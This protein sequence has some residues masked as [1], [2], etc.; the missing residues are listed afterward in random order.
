MFY[1]SR[2]RVS[3]SMPRSAPLMSKVCIRLRV[4]SPHHPCGNTSC[5]LSYYLQE[6]CKCRPSGNPQSCWRRSSS[7]V[8][9]PMVK[10]GQSKPAGLVTLIQPTA[11]SCIINTVSLFFSEIQDRPAGTP[12]TLLRRPVGR[13]HAVVL[14]EASDHVP[15]ISDQFIACTGNRDLAILLNKDTFEPDLVVLAFRENS[16]SKGT[17]GMV[18]L[19]VRSLLRRSSLS[20]TLTHCY[21]LL[22]PHPQCCGQ[23][24]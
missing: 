7:P 4:T 10:F 14:Q 23:D 13:F 9:L 20:G 18:L 8:V 19:I 22:G 16:T 3:R 24:T 2:H 5:A 11:I 6:K 12:P 15:Q 17:R 1:H 21:L